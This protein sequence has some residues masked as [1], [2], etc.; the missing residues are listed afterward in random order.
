TR[1]NGRR[2]Y[3]QSRRV[4]GRV[5]KRYCG[6]GFVSEAAATT[7]RAR[8]TLAE[9]NRRERRLR[10]DAARRLPE[11]LG[12]LDALC[13]LLSRITLEAAGFHQHARGQWRKRRAP[14]PGVVLHDRECA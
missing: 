8:R 11:E 1:R 4:C 6:R 9:C 3:Y 5:V 10:A 13:Q 14:R 7:D 12:L 2:Y